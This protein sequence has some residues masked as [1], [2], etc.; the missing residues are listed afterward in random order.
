MST[1]TNCELI[2]LSDAFVVQDLVESGE[3]KSATFFSLVPRDQYLQALQSNKKLARY[4]SLLRSCYEDA[5]KSKIQFEHDK[6]DGYE[7]V[8]RKEISLSEGEILHECRGYMERIP[9]SKEHSINPISIIDETELC[10]AKRVLVG[11]VRFANHSCV[12]NCEFLATE[13]KGRKCV[14]LAVIR[15]C[16]PGEALTVDYGPHYF[17]LNNK[18]CKCDFSDRH[19]ASSP[20]SVDSVEDAPETTPNCRLIVLKDHPDA[21]YRYRKLNFNATKKQQVKKEKSKK[22]EYRSY[23]SGTDGDSVTENSES[24][25]SSTPDLCFFMSSPKSSKIDIDQIVPNVSTI[26]P[27]SV[28]DVLDVEDQS[29]RL[30]SVKIIK[31]LKRLY[32][33]SVNWLV[34][35]FRTL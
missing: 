20:G 21:T 26:A 1:L 32:F 9:H 16:R 34:F 12:P 27:A 6:F 7:L 28:G 33:K 31:E 19:G 18:S 30:S 17:D 23:M 29:S 24:N 2:A 3:R 10:K 25:C 22:F 8:N 5:L 14:K 35:T 13:H 15:S 4:D 11:A